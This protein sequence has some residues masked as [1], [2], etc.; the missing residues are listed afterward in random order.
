MLSNLTEN[1]ETL[2]KRVAVDAG[3]F[4]LDVSIVESGDAAEALLGSTDNGCDTQQ[5]GD[6]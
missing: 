3:D 6:C 4:D 1:T 2:D 5:Q